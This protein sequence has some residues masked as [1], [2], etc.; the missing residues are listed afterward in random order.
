MKEAEFRYR[1]L[2]QQMLIGDSTKINGTYFE[3][4]PDQLIFKNYKYQLPFIEKLLWNYCYL[5]RGLTI[6]FNGEK[7]L[8]EKRSER[9]IENNMNGSPLYPIIHLKEK[10]SKWLLLIVTSYGEDYSHL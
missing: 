2:G 5:N 10:I 4:R 9:P 3:F 6:D 7:I 8:F 1:N